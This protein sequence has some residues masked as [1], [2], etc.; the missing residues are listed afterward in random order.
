MKKLF[1]ISMIAVAMIG[2]A[3]YS[4]CEKN[5]AQAATPEEDVI[6]LKVTVEGQ[7]ELTATLIGNATAR[8]F[9]SRLPLTLPMTDL[10]SREMC[11][12]FPDALFAD[13]VQTIGYEV[14]EI[15]YWPPRH[16]L[17]IMYAQNG[18]RFEMQKIGHIDSGVE[19]FKQTGDVSVTFQLPNE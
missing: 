11:Y 15:I 7:A 12:H 1:W 14:G 19:I 2:V 5:E 16:S 13:N 6:K 17:V 3:D 4:E 10:Y 18:E 9:V 8:D